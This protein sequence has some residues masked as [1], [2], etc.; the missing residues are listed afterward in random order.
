MPA[1]SVQNS[2]T[3]YLE[4]VALPQRHWIY[5]VQGGYREQYRNFHHIQIVISS[6]W[7]F[8][9]FCR[10]YDRAIALR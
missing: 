9:S 7:S 10:L 1:F 3:R 4:L 8:V 5:D 6:V 2:R